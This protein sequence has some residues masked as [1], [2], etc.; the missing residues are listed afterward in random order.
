MDFHTKFLMDVFGNV[1]CRINGAV[2]TTCAAEGDLEIGETSFDEASHMEV[3]D[4][5]DTLEEGEDFTVCFEKVD[6]GLVESCERFVLVV[7]ARVVGAATI[8]HIT[9]AV[10]AFVGRDAFLEREGE[11]ADLKKTLSSTL[12][13]Y[14]EGA[15]RDVGF[16]ILQIGGD[17]G[18]LLCLNCPTLLFLFVLGNE[19]E[20]DFFQIGVCVASA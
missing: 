11:D 3:N 13:R 7:S 8:K 9:S 12:P 17:F 16:V 19:G 5:V 18:F 15:M 10:A 20:A 14:G 4:F 6:D 2:A 1:L